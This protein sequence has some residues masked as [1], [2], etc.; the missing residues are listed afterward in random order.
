MLFGHEP[1]DSATLGRMRGPSGRKARLGMSALMWIS[2]LEQPLKSDELCYAIVVEIRS[3]NFNTDNFP[4][5]R[6]SP[7]CCQGLVV[8]DKGTSTIRLVHFTT[9]GL[10]PSF[11]VRSLDNCGNLLKLSKFA[12][13]QSSPSYLPSRSPIHTVSRIF[14]S[15]LENACKTGAFGLRKIACSKVI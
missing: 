10:I 15:V 11:L 14:L 3:P 4:S 6:T 9:S 12:T 7:A 1:R 2:H 13:C 8:M 5:I